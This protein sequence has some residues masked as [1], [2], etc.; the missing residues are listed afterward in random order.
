MWKKRIKYLGVNLPKEARYLYTENYDTDERNQR[1]HRQMERHTMFLD[2]KNQY[3]EKDYTSQSNL[4][5]QWNPY[6]VTNG[7]FHRTR[8]KNFTVHMKQKTLNSQS[9]L[10]KEEWS[11]RNPPSW[12]QII[13]QSYSHQ[14]S[15]VLAQKQKYRPMEQDRRPRN[16]P[17]YLWVPYS[18]Q[19]RQ[20]YSMGQRQSLQ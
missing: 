5:I 9:S 15:V 12:L 13:V 18:W 20:E 1:W 6:Q 17:M 7:I 16:K 2:W 4:Q 14:G 11:W 8:T 10:E 19:R 3:C